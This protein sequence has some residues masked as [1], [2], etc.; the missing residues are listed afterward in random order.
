MTTSQIKPDQISS[1]EA[2]GALLDIERCLLLVVDVQVDFAAPDGAMALF[3]ADLSAVA[4]SIARMRALIAAA[5]ARGLAIGWLRVLTDPTTDNPA[6]KRFYAWRG[7]PPSALNVCRDGERGS[8]YYELI[9]ECGDLQVEKRQY[10][11]F[12]GTELESLLRARQVQSLLL[13]G[14]TTECCID[15]TARD[16]FHRGFDVIIPSDACAAYA[17][18]TH[19]SALANLSAN[20]ALLTDTITL[21][22]CLGQ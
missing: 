10:S 21:L 16:A 1:P 2:L 4:P 9:P 18:A 15:C 5:R 3:G 8:A 6:A 13:V 20:C 22:R 11:G 19:W 17:E 12:Y 7:L 14:L